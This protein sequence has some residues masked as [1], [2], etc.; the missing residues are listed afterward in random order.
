LIIAI[1]R[2]HDLNRATWEMSA[3]EGA[4]TFA[5]SQTLPDVDYAALAT[6]LDLEAIT[7]D[8]PDQVGPAWDLA[9]AT[10]PASWMSGPMRTCSNPAACDL[11]PG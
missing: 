11:R 8:K 1:L 3:M 6:S 9:L 4:S 10:G 7:V 5:E 2:N